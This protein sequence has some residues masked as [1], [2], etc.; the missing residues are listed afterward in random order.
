MADRLQQIPKQIL[1]WWNKFTSKQKT[2]IICVGAVVVL[3][4]AI[5]G[6][7]LSRPQY[8]QLAVCEDTKESATISELLEGE[9]IKPRISTDGLKIDVLTKDLSTANLILGKNN[10]PTTT[11]A[12][13]NVF[14]GGFNTTELD[15]QRRYKAYLEGQMQESI[16]SYE[17]V[18][19]ARVSI[20]LPTND[21][22]LIAKEEEGFVS[23]ILE[24]D[25]EIPTE[26]ANAI[27]V[28][29]KN[30]IGNK[31]ANNIVIMDT[32]GNLLYSGEDNY[33]VSGSASNQL[34]VKQQYENVI[35]NE[36]KKV[37]IGTGQFGKIEVASN[38]VL[39][40]S[41][42][43]KTIHKFEPADGQTQGVLT[44]EDIYTSESSGGTSGPP[45]T[46]SNTDSPTYAYKDSDY[47]NQTTQEESRDYA[48]NETIITQNIPPG[49][50]KYGESSVSVT[51]TNFKMLKEE[52]AKSQGLLDGVTW[53]EYKL[54]NAERKKMTV[55]EDLVNVVSKAT[56]IS[57]EDISLVAYEEP[58]FVDKEGLA[59]KPADIIQIVLIVL[60]LG[61]LAF[62]VL[63]SMKAEKTQEVEAELSVENLLQSTPQA[64]LEDI[65]LEAKSETRKLIEKFVEENP[66]AVANLLRNWLNEDWG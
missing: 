9:G 28:F 33:S 20:D 38:L 44:H 62:V 56:G 59:V 36:V 35:K 42:S 11:Y 55:D 17:F 13:E 66:E 37:L 58:V 41:S 32:M 53:E 14:A 47:S 54:A 31:T 45:G 5:L 27:A 26:A 24:L 15:K 63:R 39:D 21:G 50:I 3:A 34:S 6:T 52:D 43:D 65:E 2:I 64:E 57:V 8:T 61:L 4:L 22:T 29:S 18:K 23:I 25:G 1:E 30:V 12:L 48:P 19:S 40:F 7:V 10:I 46:D 16:G 60:I 51:A 49:A